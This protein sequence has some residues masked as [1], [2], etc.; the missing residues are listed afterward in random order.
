MN[1]P[2]TRRALLG[3]TAAIGAVGLPVVAFASAPPAL[4][5]DAALFDLIERYKVL[6]VAWFAADEHKDEVWWCAWDAH[7]SRP[8][9]LRYEPEDFPRTS[10]AAG[11]ADQAE[12]DGSRWYGARGVEWLRCRH[13]PGSW[14]P[15]GEARRR[16]IVEAWDG[17]T[18]ACAVVD[19]QFGVGAAREALKQAHRDALSC[20]SAIMEHVPATPAGIQAK[21]A[22]ILSQPW[23][24]EQAVTFLRQIAGDLTPIDDIKDADDRQ[25]AA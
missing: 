6:D 10:Y 18:A 12:E 9:A 8:T 4:D 3:A 22:W 16:E 13:Q 5:V 14:T 17:W 11:A 2:V 21:A 1:A 25:V 24:Q 20:Q 19:E 23:P 15:E 7:P